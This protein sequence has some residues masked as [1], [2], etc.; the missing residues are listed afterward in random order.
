MNTFTDQLLIVVKWT[1][2]ARVRQAAV[3]FSCNIILL[4]GN[5]GKVMY[6][7]SGSI[8]LRFLKFLYLDY[9]SWIYFTTNF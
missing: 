4:T 7:I 6:Y 5:C 8:T 3:A 9:H 2:G 1:N